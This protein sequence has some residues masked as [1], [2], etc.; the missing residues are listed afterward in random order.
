MTDTVEK[1]MGDGDALTVFSE[2]VGLNYTRGRRYQDLPDVGPFVTEKREVTCYPSSAMHRAY[3][4]RDDV[5]MLV[6]FQ[7]ISKEAGDKVRALMPDFDE[8]KNYL[9]N[10]DC[11][12]QR[13]AGWMVLLTQKDMRRTN[14][15]SV[16][17]FA[18]PS[19]NFEPYAGKYECRIVVVMHKQDRG[20]VT[21]EYFYHR[22]REGRVK[23]QIA[24]IGEV[25]KFR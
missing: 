10:E 9:G 2:K 20:D 8:N 7:A 22:K 18:V 14:A 1:K 24:K 23:K 5:M 17:C 19:D 21:V 4:K 16:F 3:D 25:L 13:E 15:D 6:N 12:G 11:R